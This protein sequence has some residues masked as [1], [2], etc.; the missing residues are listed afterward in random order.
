MFTDEAEFYSQLTKLL[1]VTK[2]PVLMTASSYQYVDKHLLP[3]LNRHET[4]VRYECLDYSHRRPLVSDMEAICLLIKLFEGF[5]SQQLDFIPSFNPILQGKC[6]QQ[7]VEFLA[8]SR[9][10]VKRIVTS[11]QSVP[12]VINAL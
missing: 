11:Q 1:L 7:A 12:A 2:V 4:E 6:S 9:S 3:I 10:V 5:V 8:Q